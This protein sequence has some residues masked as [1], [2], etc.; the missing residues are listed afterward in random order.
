MVVLW[1]TRLQPAPKFDK[2]FLLA[3][4]PVALFHT[5]GHV[6]ACVSFS[7]MAVSFA[8]IVKA[9]EPV[10]TASGGGRAAQQ[11]L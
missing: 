5:V 2:G 10:S 9:A 11:A 8:H 7:Q 4:L 1:V 6:S 3:L